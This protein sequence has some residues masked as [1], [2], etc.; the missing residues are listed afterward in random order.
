MAFF[1]HVSSSSPAARD[2]M[3]EEGR[4]PTL[5][6][7]Q[8][9]RDGVSSKKIVEFHSQLKGN[10]GKGKGKTTAKRKKS[11]ED[12]RR[13]EGAAERG[14]AREERRQSGAGDASRVPLPSPSPLSFLSGQRPNS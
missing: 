7:S 11:W 5:L 1:A 9:F 13:G 3:R 10:G 14:E 12:K 4:Q 8:V 2:E 6:P